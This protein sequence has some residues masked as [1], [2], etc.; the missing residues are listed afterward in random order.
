MCVSDVQEGRLSRSEQLIV[1]YFYSAPLLDVAFTSELSHR[2]FESITGL[3]AGRGADYSYFHSRSHYYMPTW[4][5]VASED[6]RGN[7]P[8]LRSLSP[9]PVSPPSLMVVKILR[10]CNGSYSTGLSSLI[11][12]ADVH[13]EVSV[14]TSLLFASNTT[15]PRS[16]ES[17]HYFFSLSRRDPWQAVLDTWPLPRMPRANDATASLKSI[18]AGQCGGDVHSLY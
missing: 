9:F 3:C 13:V 16:R 12:T 2:L 10:N 4:A 18:I 15:V 6:T 17:V 1:G 7:C 14:Q 8:P 5:F 11:Y